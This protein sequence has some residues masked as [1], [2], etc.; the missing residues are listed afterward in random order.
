MILNYFKVGTISSELVCI[1]VIMHLIVSCH[2]MIQRIV[3]L[4]LPKTAPGQ[5]QTIYAT[6]W[7]TT[8]DII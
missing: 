3:L 1:T 7:K 8:N 2:L 6:A 5:L 4:I